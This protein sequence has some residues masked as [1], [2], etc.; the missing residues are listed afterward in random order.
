M[1]AGT[2]K[3]PTQGHGPRADGLSLLDEKVLAMIIGQNPLE[4]TLGALCTS[5]TPT[6]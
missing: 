1:S 2:Q 4:R 3:A 6:G 5:L